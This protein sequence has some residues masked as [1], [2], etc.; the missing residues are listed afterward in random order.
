MQTMLAGQ[1]KKTELLVLLVATAAAGFF[2]LLP[3]RVMLEH[4]IYED[5][6]YY[7]RVAEYLANGQGSTFD[8]TAP[9]NGYH[10]A[11]M[12]ITTLFAL[13][14]EG[15]ALVRVMLILAAILHGAQAVMLHRILARF[16]PGPVALGL[17]ALFALNWRVISTNL[18]G[19][20]T[21]LSLLMMLVILDWLIRHLPEEAPRTGTAIV[22]GLLLGVAVYAR[23]DMLLFAALVLVFYAV[24]TFNRAG[25]AAALTRLVTAG[26]VL[27]ATLVPWFIFSLSV[28]G[29][30]LPNSR[31]AVRLLG[32][33]GPDFSSSE[34]IAASVHRII[35]GGI[36]WVTDNA[37][38]LGTWPSA[39]PEGRLSQIAALILTLFV[40]WVVV[41]AVRA[42]RR[43]S[44]V[45]WLCL[46]FFGLHAGYYLVNY[47]LEVRYVLPAFTAFLI[48]LGMVLGNRESGLWGL[49][50]RYTGVL[51]MVLL[52]VATIAGVHA[53]S[54]Y[55]GTTR[56]HQGHA[57]L[58]DA[59]LWI[60]EN[61]PDA[62]IG[63]WN[64][65]IMSYFSRAEV[66][67]LDGVINDDAL[68]ANRAG[69]IDEYIKARGITYL[70]DGRGQI[71]SNLQRFAGNT[72]LMGAVQAD[73]NGV[74]VLA[75]KNDE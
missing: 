15:E 28:S 30:L 26:T 33:G 55:H 24:L 46:I 75:V 60:R 20:E 13:M 63:S 68:R 8:G 40:L 23:F 71:E 35:F 67:N 61:E 14:F 70:A 34:A 38:L 44:P 9:T 41:S 17:T 2:A 49:P 7:L 18:C 51:P 21:P 48:V 5:M 43:L 25:P 57:W 42:R 27:V 47:R 10:P 1:T 64:A 36:H 12:A 6:F 29:T 45:V 32:G 52:A 11:W 31:E 50:T 54:K 56:T 59:A 58:Y 19:L 37:N 65:G 4:F 3:L 69:A 16:A 72:D 22:L 53:W 73:F 62:T 39:M 66:V 74:V